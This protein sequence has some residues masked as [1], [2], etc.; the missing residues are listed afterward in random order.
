M[1]RN[2]ECLD[3]S[4]AKASEIVSIVSTDA[5]IRVTLRDGTT[6]MV[7]GGI[8]EFYALRDRCPWAVAAMRSR[9]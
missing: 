6:G 5:G 8:A 1:D 9:R 7:G 3:I 2:T 4:G